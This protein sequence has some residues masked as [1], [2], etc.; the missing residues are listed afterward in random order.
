MHQNT[1]KIKEES[2]YMFAIY[3]SYMET[4]EMN[5]INDMI[6]RNNS[7]EELWF[8]QR[9]LMSS[10]MRIQFLMCIYDWSRMEIQFVHWN[11]TIYYS[12]DHVFC[13]A[14]GSK[15]AVTIQGLHLTIVYTAWRRCPIFLFLFCSACSIKA[16][17]SSILKHQVQRLKLILCLLLIKGVTWMLPK[18]SNIDS[19]FNPI[20]LWNGHE[21]L[22]LTC[23]QT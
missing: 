13:V 12:W 6:Y 1:R 17:S 23:V 16:D 19:H 14:D 11:E 20:N 5:A 21:Y 7:P 15:W 10:G 8:G 9:Y 22:I 3:C 18:L 4:L 2:T